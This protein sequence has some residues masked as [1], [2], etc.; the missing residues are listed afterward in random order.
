MHRQHPDYRGVTDAWGMGGK[1]LPIGDGVRKLPGFCQSRQWWPGAPISLGSGLS[2]CCAIYSAPPVGPLHSLL[3]HEETG[4]PQEHTAGGMARAVWP[5][6]PPSREDVPHKTRTSSPAGRRR[7]GH[8]HVG[9]KLWKA[10]ST[11]CRTWAPLLGHLGLKRDPKIQGEEGG[12]CKASIVPPLPKNNSLD[13]LRSNPRCLLA[14]ELP[15][16]PCLERCSS[17]AFLIQEQLHLILF[18]SHPWTTVLV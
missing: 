15:P 7:W 12:G 9:W 6:R 18:R 10:S 1:V 4:R 8:Q 17:A 14:G 11:S 3:A 13:D 16:H 2:L 5:Q